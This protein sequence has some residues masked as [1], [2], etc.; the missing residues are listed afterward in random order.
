MALMRRY[1]AGLRQLTSY[2]AETKFIASARRSKTKAT[3][4][5]AAQSEVSLLL[6]GLLGLSIHGR[7]QPGP[8]MRAILAADEYAEAGAR[9]YLMP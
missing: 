2:S 6:R 3:H 9:P 1:D 7:L 4:L 8:A 5:N